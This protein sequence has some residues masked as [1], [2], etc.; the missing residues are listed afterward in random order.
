MT[1]KRKEAEDSLIVRKCSEIIPG[2]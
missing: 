2:S 1:M